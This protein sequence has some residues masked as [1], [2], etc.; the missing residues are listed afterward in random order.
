MALGYILW[1]HLSFDG[2]KVEMRIG[3]RR[4]TAST[5]SN[6]QGV[7]VPINHH[8]G[9]EALVDEPETFNLQKRDRYPT[10][11]PDAIDGI[12]EEINRIDTKGAPSREYRVTLS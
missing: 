10:D 1:L 5:A 9:S 6:L 8:H 2:D 4:K 3:R 7:R 12:Q 11:P